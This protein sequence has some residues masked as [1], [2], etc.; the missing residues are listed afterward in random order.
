MNKGCW[1]RHFTFVNAASCYD[2]VAAYGALESMLLT[3]ISWRLY[4]RHKSPA[5]ITDLTDVNRFTP[6]VLLLHWTVYMIHKEINS[7]QQHALCQHTRAASWSKM[8]STTCKG[9]LVKT[10][11]YF[12]C[13]HNH[14]INV[15]MWGLGWTLQRRAR[16]TQ[17][18][19]SVW[20]VNS[21]SA[22]TV[23][24]A[25]S[26]PAARFIHWRYL[27]FISTVLTRFI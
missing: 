10:N 23:H 18:F 14:D 17:I 6:E 27:T 21:S 20:T 12:L 15:T 24:V 25:K 26:K 16:A 8:L 13:V 22:L 11:S 1:K 7:S 5:C 3:F 4:E 9:I 19:V 2:C